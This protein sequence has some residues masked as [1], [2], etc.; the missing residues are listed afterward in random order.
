VK[1]ERW[2]G[3]VELFERCLELPPEERESF[4][5]DIDDELR[6]EVEAWLAADELEEGLESSDGTRKGP[7][8]YIDRE[9]GPWRTT[10]VIGEG[11]MGIVLS[12]ERA[13]GAFELAAAL[14]L[15]RTELRSSSALRAFHRERAALAR[16]DHPGIAR[17]LDGGTEDGLPWLV[18]EGVRGERIDRWCDERGLSTSARVELFLEACRAVDHA[19]RKLIVHRDLKPAH[20]IVTPDGQVKVLDFGIAKLLD[21]E[22]SG[23]ERS[24]LAFTPEYASPEQLRGEA[25]SVATD[26]HAL[27]LVLYELL[28]GRRAFTASADSTYEL[29]KQICEE[30]APTASGIV[31]ANEEP[32]RDLARVRAATPAKLRRVLRGDLDAI[33][34]KALRKEPERRYAS[35]A[36]LAGD[37]KAYLRGRPVQARRGGLRYRGGKLLRRRW[38]ET[39]AAVVVLAL[40]SASAWRVHRSELRAAEDARAGAES[41]AVL[42]QLIEDFETGR[43]RATPETVLTTIE[44]AEALLE[45]GAD[46]RPEVELSLVSA[47]QSA[48]GA[49]GFRDTILWHSRRAWELARELHGPDDARTLLYAAMHAD[50]LSRGTDQAEE[51]LRLASDVL[52]RLGPEPSNPSVRARVLV[53]KSRSLYSLGSKEEALVAAEQGV[54][55]CR[56]DLDGAGDQAWTAFYFLAN[57]RLARGES[58]L[59]ITVGREAVELMQGR[60]LDEP[61]R[62]A[63]VQRVLALSLQDAGRFE[64]ALPVLRESIEFVGEIRP[65]SVD[66]FISNHV[67]LALL[68]KELQRYDEALEACDSAAAMSRRVDA[69]PHQKRM[70]V[71]ARGKT[72]ADARR[73]REALA[74]LED[75]AG[76]EQEPPVIATLRA[77]CLIELGRE[78]EAIAVLETGLVEIRR[79]LVSDHWEIPKAE[80]VLGWALAREGRFAEAEPLVLGGLEGVRE[81]RGPHH[82]RTAEALQR[83]VEFYEL[84]GL[85]DRAQP[86]REAL[87]AALE[88]NPRADRGNVRPR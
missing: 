47:I 19:H 43:G 64:E 4:L 85:E 11:G 52:A 42:Q 37:L 86:H 39:A 65:N 28:T 57:L 16:L 88:A 75:N 83:A 2:E 12:V 58:E 62:L 38:R 13:D 36:E 20:V 67:H 1:E 5:A 27:G 41:V 70:I 34:A 46:L 84:Q 40:L 73:W 69:A 32:S 8:R 53:A 80:S 56:D 48:R 76:A 3:V 24:L 22:R 29:S 63:D 78:E 7:A 21:D 9:F 50:V 54:A 51:A 61:S 14:K 82:H 72:L 81:G 26:V 66:Y 6:E 55:L 71:D 59:A 79:M 30:E 25:I 45:G 15:L 10:E 17:L 44:A 87:A 35:V 33:L 18:M 31:G 49:L 68:L 23:D 74:A 77:R 60:E